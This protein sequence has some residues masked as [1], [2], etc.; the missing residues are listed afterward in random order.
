MQGLSMGNDGL[1][2][3]SFIRLGGRKNGMLLPLERGS[4]IGAGQP[5]KREKQHFPTRKFL[6]MPAGHRRPWR[7]VESGLLHLPDRRK[8]RRNPF[9]RAWK[10]AERERRHIWA[11]PVNKRVLG[12]SG[13][14]CFPLEKP[15]RPVLRGHVSPMER[16]FRKFRKNPFHLLSGNFRQDNPAAFLSRFQPRG[17]SGRAV[18]KCPMSVAG[19]CKS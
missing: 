14:E 7:I 10:G 18:K 16:I 2:Q 11:M 12:A 1:F 3:E 4:F 17:F 5:E 6:W 8:D 13:G 15:T 9:K 19:D